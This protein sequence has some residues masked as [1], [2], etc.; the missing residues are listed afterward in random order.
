VSFEASRVFD[1][2]T[3]KSSQSGVGDSFH[4]TRDHRNRVLPHARFF[5]RDFRQNF[6]IL[7]QLA[8][9]QATRGQG[10]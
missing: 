1:G 4:K 3:K 2:A 7:R 10:G 8:G 5:E 6:F 9:R